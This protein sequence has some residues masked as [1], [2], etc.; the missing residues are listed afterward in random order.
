MSLEQIKSIAI[1]G[2]AGSGKTTIARELGSKL[3]W[4]VF[5]A[6]ELYRI[7]CERN[8]MSSYGAELAGDSV[9]DGIDQ[10]MIE[11]M[12]KGRTIEEGRVAGLVAVVNNLPG[13]LKVLLVCSAEERVRRIFARD[14]EL[15]K[16]LAEARYVTNERE[17]S[18]LRVFTDRYG[19]RSYLNRLLYD[20]TV[21]TKRFS[22]EETTRLIMNRVTN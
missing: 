2:E 22:V 16:D 17:A 12:K 21:D 10:M 9:H 11:E 4:E 5:G 14:P 18:N 8:G 6:G 15:Y 7:W 19:G 13:V 3:G 20:M 1:A